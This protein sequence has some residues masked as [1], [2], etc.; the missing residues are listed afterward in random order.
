MQWYKRTFL[1][2]D[3]LFSC[4]VP[5]LAGPPRSSSRAVCSSVQ[6]SWTIAPNAPQ[7]RRNQ[8]IRNSY[9]GLP[10]HTVTPESTF[11]WFFCACGSTA[12]APVTQN[13]SK[14]MMM[15][16]GSMQPVLMVKK[17]LHVRQMERAFCPSIRES[18]YLTERY[19]L[20][21][22]ARRQRQRYVQKTKKQSYTDRQRTKV[23][24]RFTTAEKLNLDT[25]HTDRQG[26]KVRVRFTTA[27]KLNLDTP[28]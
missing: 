4:G 12:I 27:D 19:H 13:T 22:R 11:H 26:T 8:L 18:R 25:A 21:R 15:L 9:C 17:H 5:G 1:L 16:V 2:I 10:F 6:P 23:R 20:R 7:S 28:P 14:N 3:F 24:V